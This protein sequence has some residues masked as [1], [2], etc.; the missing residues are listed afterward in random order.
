[1]QIYLQRDIY[2]LLRN[3]T[4]IYFY[5]P[6]FKT[7]G[8]ENIHLT[9]S[10]IN[11]MC[12]ANVAKV[13]Y[14][15]NHPGNVSLYPDIQNVAFASIAEIEDIP[16]NFVVLPEIYHVDKIRQTTGIINCQY[17]VWWQ[18]FIN[19]CVNNALTNWSLPGVLHAFHSYYEYA[20]VRPHLTLGQTYFFLTDFIAEEYTSTKMEEFLDEKEPIVCFN[21]H[22]DNLSKKLCEEAKIPFIEIKNMDREGVNTVLKKCQVYVDMGSHPGKDH[23]PREAAMYGCV[24]IT[25][26]SGSAAYHEDVPIET[27]VIHE[28][29]LI[30]LVEEVLKNYTSY[31]SKQTSYRKMICDEKQTAEKNISNFLLLHNQIVSIYN[32]IVFVPQPEYVK[33]IADHEDILKRLEEICIESVGSIEVEGNCFCEN[34]NITNRLS[35]L[36]PK[37]MNLYSLGMFAKN[38]LEIGFNAGH[39]ALLFLLANPT[40]K[41]VCFDICEHPYT[42][43]CFEYLQS[44]FKDRIELIIGDSTITIPDYKQK[45]P[46][47]IFD[48]FHL[49]GSHDVNVAKKDFENAYDITKD[50][51][52]FDDTQDSILSNLLDKFIKNRWVI[53]IQMRKTAKYEHRIV[54][55][56]NGVKISLTE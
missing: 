34:K 37:Q 13:I 14:I 8:P 16:T 43:K 7:G 3:E 36:I 30:P 52:I 1:M 27:K 18:S 50:V 22:K 9:V 45:H 2:I 39:S 21:G 20:M 31:L 53:E 47:T 38:V 12:N 32:G 44:I 26:K 17:V 41:V 29:E 19:A 23:M 42:I 48:V 33:K 51:I 10:I 35:E 28:S 24:V 6:F 15:T 55:K 49:D 54:R 40:S 25:N 46:N 11:Q 5:S 4:M 56:L